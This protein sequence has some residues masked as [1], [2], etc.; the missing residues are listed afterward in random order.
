M[1]S[2]WLFTFL[3]GVSCADA[4]GSWFLS[5]RSP[6][7]GLDASSAGM[8]FKE[9]PLPTVETV[10]AIATNITFE[11]NASSYPEAQEPQ[12]EVPP[13]QEA[14]KTTS[15]KKR[16][17]PVSREASLIDSLQHM[18]VD[19]GDT[20][21][22]V[23]GCRYGEEVRHTWRECLE[24]CVANHLVR[25]TLMAML[26]EEHHAAKSMDAEVPHGLEVP[27]AVQYKKILKKMRSSEL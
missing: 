26:P 12:Q 3:A 1:Q 22:C 10:T 20:V 19:D 2:L 25:S 23:S 16:R 21:G 17:R 27:D 5:R 7:L 13:A 11:K 9:E 18:G 6:A 24:R 14:N 4:G 15:S 8:I